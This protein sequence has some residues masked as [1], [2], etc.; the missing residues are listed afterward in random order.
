MVELQVDISSALIV[1]MKVEGPNSQL[2]AHRIIYY[3]NLFI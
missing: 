2:V 1:L 3:D